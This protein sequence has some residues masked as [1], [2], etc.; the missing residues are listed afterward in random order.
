MPFDLTR[1]RA[2]LTAAG[3]TALAATAAGSAHTAPRSSPGTR[4]PAAAFPEGFRWGTAT[5]SYQVEGATHEAGRGP[6]I[7]DTF[8]QQP[9]AS[10][11]ARPARSASITST[12]T[13]KT[14][15]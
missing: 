10:G 12:A 4:R 3:A 8:T 11:T 13:R 6:S 1:R 5:S 7:W 2:L 14:W 15:R 9:A